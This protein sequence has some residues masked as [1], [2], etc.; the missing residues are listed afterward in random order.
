MRLPA[1]TRCR[2]RSTLANILL[3]FSLKPGYEIFHIG[4]ALTAFGGDD[5]IRAR[6]DEFGVEWR[7]QRT[8]AYE[9]LDQ[10]AAPERHALAIDRREHDLIVVAEMQRA[11]GF[12]IRQPDRLQPHGPIERRR[13]TR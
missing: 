11:C 9:A 13:A 3:R 6:R 12:Q 4:I 5:V 8:F 2:E 1:P 7:V 10:G